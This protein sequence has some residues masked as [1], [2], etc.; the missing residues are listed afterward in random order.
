MIII[1][2]SKEEAM[3]EIVGALEWD[4]LAAVAAFV[5]GFAVPGG[6]TVQRLLASN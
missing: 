3:E 1:F 4:A 2:L 5:L 6:P